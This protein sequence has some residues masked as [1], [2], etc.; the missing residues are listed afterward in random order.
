MATPQN[1]ETLLSTVD[2]S[3]CSLEAEIQSAQEEVPA[4]KR[5]VGELQACSARNISIESFQS[6]ADQK[7][8]ADLLGSLRKVLDE[9]AVSDR[10]EAALWTQLSTVIEQM[11][12]AAR[13]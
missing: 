5:A 4:A 8:I 9:A 11:A 10:A 1:L 13:D 3:V 7:T 2:R 6:V 12:R